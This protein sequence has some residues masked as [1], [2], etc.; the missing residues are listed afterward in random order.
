MKNDFQYQLLQIMEKLV[1][2]HILILTYQ[3][4]IMQVKEI[5]TF[6]GQIFHSQ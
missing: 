5:Q 3:L 2:I 1:M 4:Q 6:L